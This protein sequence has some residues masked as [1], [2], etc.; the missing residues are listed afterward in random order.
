MAEKS[1]GYA[2]VTGATKGIGYELAKLLA[3]DGYSIV[4]VARTQEDLEQVAT[5]FRGY[6]VAVEPIA[7]DLFGETA[8]TELYNE[9]RGR[10]IE[11]EILVNDAGQGVYGLFTDTDIE[12]QMRIIHLNIVSLTRLTYHFLKD[13]KARN[14]GRILQLGSIVS[15]VPSPWQAVYGG[16]KAYVLSFT[17]ALISELKESAVTL[18]VL[19]PGATDTDFFN[20]AGAQESRI[21]ADPGKLADPAQVAKDGYAALMKGDDKVVSG[22]KNKTQSVLSNILPD[23][24]LADQMNKQSEPVDKDKKKE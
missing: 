3:Q 1:K 14:S 2:L 22:L 7:K 8:A 15:E 17:E 10:G 21:V 12:A 6:G 23:T 5:E 13:M 11:V 18:T 4:A 19:Q 20:K 9:V 16:T 24:L